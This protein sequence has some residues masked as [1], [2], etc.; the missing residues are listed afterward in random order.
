MARTPHRLT[1]KVKSV[2]DN[3]GFGFIVTEQGAEEYFFHFSGCTDCTF[4]ELHPGTR[5]TFTPSES[6]K[7]LRAENIGLA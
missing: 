4:A 3:K 2:V 5:V 7:G 6:P 1:G